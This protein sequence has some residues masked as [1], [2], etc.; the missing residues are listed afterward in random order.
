MIKNFLHI[1]SILF[2]FISSIAAADTYKKE[3]VIEINGIQ[4]VEHVSYKI[5]NYAVKNKIDVVDKYGK[6]IDTKSITE[7]EIYIKQCDLMDVVSDLYSDAVKDAKE[8]SETIIDRAKELNDGT[9]VTILRGQVL[10]IDNL[11]FL[12]R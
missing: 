7:T 11:V 8:D 3:D 6:N 1:V 4:M 2:I 10:T 5:V 12:L 9:E